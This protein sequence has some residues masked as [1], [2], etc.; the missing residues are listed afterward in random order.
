MCIH[1]CVRT[2]PT[3]RNN[4]ENLPSFYPIITE[5]VLPN[6]KDA[7]AASI[8]LMRRCLYTEV[9]TR[10]RDDASAFVQTSTAVSACVRPPLNGARASI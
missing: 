1:N 2:R 6:G 9:A 8:V 3:T 5:Q 10:L 7:D 4:S